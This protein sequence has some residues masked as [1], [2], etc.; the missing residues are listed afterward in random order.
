MVLVL[1]VG[2]LV[3]AVLVLRSP[4]AHP[5]PAIVVASLTSAICFT[6]AGVAAGGGAETRGLIGAGS[7]AGLLSVVGAT[8]AL[9]PTK[10]TTPAPRTALIVSTLG[11]ALGA[12]QLLLSVLV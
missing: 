11:I 10:P 2:L 9:W 3:G 1:G 4:N 8:I 5:W 6:V 12:F 7:V